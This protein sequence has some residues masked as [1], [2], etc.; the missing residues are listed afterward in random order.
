VAHVLEQANTTLTGLARGIPA[1]VLWALRGVGQVFFQ[2]NALTGALFLLGIAASSPT[3][4]IGAVLGTAIGTA[5]GWALK[6]DEGETTGG[7]YGFNATL[8]GIATFFFF[9]PGVGSVTLLIVGCAAS[10]LVTRLARRYLPF[11]TYTGPFIVTTWA[12]FFAGVAFGLARVDAGGPP[13]GLDL[14]RAT[15]HGVSQVMFQASIW[16]ALLFL[17]GIAAS[18][19]RHAALVLAGSVVGMFVGVSHA[20][21]GNHELLGTVTLGI[22]G[23]NAPLAAVA[24]YLARPSLTLP[25]L[26]MVVAAL[27]TDLFSAVGLPALTAPFVLGTWIVLGLLWLQKVIPSPGHAPN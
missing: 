20:A 17:A 4:A 18:D 1:P 26:G 5:V 14:F 10:T 16:T 22:Y 15:A 23:Y 7:I 11:P 24:L 6:F 27:L 12:M 13:G 9:Q 21:A 8:V 3:M 2:E 25:L 19:W